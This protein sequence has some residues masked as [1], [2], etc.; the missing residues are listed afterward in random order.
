MLSS[1]LS[2]FSYALSALA[3]YW[4]RYDLLLIARFLTGLFE[5]NIAI[6]RAIVTDLN[7]VIDKTKAFSLIFAAT[8]TGWLIGP[9]L[10]GYTVFLGEAAAFIIASACTALSVVA[11]YFWIPETHA[12]NTS[13]SFK[14]IIAVAKAQNSLKLIAHRPVRMIAFTYLLLCLGLSAFYGFFPLL[15]AQKFNFISPEIANITLTQTAAMILFSVLI[16]PRLKTKFGFKTG[17]LVGLLTL[18]VSLS[19]VFTVSKDYLFVYF[20][21]TGAAIGLYSGLLSAYISERYAYLEQGRLMGMLTSIYC[22]S[23]ILIAPIGGVIS[24]YSVDNSIVFG[25][26]LFSLGTLLFWR[27]SSRARDQSHQAQHTLATETAN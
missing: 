24:S 22:L 8:Y 1:V 27:F 11:I 26:L 18:A 12:G 10:G 20:F 16:G 5:G 23:S 21:I 15:L 3:V 19:L 2:A 17:I 13:S 25:G 4:Q 7:P 6:G 9:V 14:Q